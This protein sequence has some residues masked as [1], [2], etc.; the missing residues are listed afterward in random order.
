MQQRLVQE[1][2]DICTID[3]GD[4]FKSRVNAV[5][6]N[7]ER[8]VEIAPT[9]PLRGSAACTRSALAG[10]CAHLMFKQ[11]TKVMRLEIRTEPRD[12]MMLYGMF[13]LLAV[14]LHSGIQSWRGAE[15]NTLDIMKSRFSIE[16]CLRVFLSPHP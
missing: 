4:L 5:L 3:F 14:E 12:Q 10:A 15:T 1:Q 6:E 2:S 9:R 11:I 13:S 8:Q 16:T 7:S